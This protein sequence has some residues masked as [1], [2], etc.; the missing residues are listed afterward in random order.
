MLRLGRGW[1]D[2][3]HYDEA[4]ALFDKSAASPAANDQIKKIAASYKARAQD[5]QKQQK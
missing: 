5:Q 2:V 1:V 4:I 3:K